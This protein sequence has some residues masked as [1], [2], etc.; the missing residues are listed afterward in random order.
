MCE[1]HLRNG[2]EFGLIEVMQCGEAGGA[3]QREEVAGA[4]RKPGSHLTLE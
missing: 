3:G 2:N 1:L 4:E